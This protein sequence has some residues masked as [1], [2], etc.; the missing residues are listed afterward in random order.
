MSYLDLRLK[1]PTYLESQGIDPRKKFLCIHPEHKEQTPSS[2]VYMNKVVKCFGCGKATDIFETAHLLEGLPGRKSPSFFRDNVQVLAKRFGVL[3]PHSYSSTTIDI[4][5]MVINFITGEYAEEQAKSAQISKEELIRD[6]APKRFQPIQEDHPIVLDSPPFPHLIKYLMDRGFTKYDINEAGIVPY[7]FSKQEGAS[8]FPLW[9]NK[10]VCVG[11]IRR[12]PD[13][14]KPKYLSTPNNPVFVKTDYLYGTHFFLDKEQPL[15][16]VEGQKDVL[17]LALQSVQ[18][19]ALSGNDMSDSQFNQ[20]LSLPSSGIVM[21]LDNDERTSQDK[22]LIKGQAKMHEAIARFI[23]KGIVPGVYIWATKDANDDYSKGHFVDRGGVINGLEWYLNQINLS[24]ESEIAK[25]LGLLSEVQGNLTRLSLINQVAE[26]TGLDAKYLREDVDNLIKSKQDKTTEKV[27]H[28]YKA[29]YDSALKDPEKATDILTRAIKQADSYNTKNKD[30]YHNNELSG[31]LSS[32]SHNETI[33]SE[34]FEFY[35]FGLKHIMDY[36]SEDS[37]GWA[38]TG[39]LNLIPGVSHSGKTMFL[40][41]HMAEVLFNNINSQ[42]FLLST[43]DSTELILPRVIAALMCDKEYQIGY[44]KNQQKIP[45][46]LRHRFAKVMTFLRTLVQQ[47]RLIIKDSSSITSASTMY[48]LIK[49]YRDKYPERM[50]ILYNDNFHR[51]M[52]HREKGELQRVEYA[53]ADMKN[54]VTSEKMS[55][56]C[57]A[58]KRKTSTTWVEPYDIPANNDDILG[59]GALTYYAS[60]II[61]TVNDYVQ[62]G[63]DISKC[64]WVHTKGKELLPQS[65]LKITKNKINGRLGVFVANQYPI[66]NILEPTNTSEAYNMAFNRA[67]EFGY[68]N[69]KRES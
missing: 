63:K 13:G 11:F 15:F 21:A 19:V 46:H 60:I 26:M 25:L 58:E 68:F 48:D 3:L 32:L 10:D 38:K 23:K 67:K 49:Y 61:H 1:L 4:Y 56:W 24:D 54:F 20:I 66:S 52:D 44:M 37:N 62:R 9:T 57:S 40:V 8:L 28:I 42:V 35:G 39:S 30:I 41:Q 22:G 16:V 50:P 27:L 12:M 31:I 2:H 14:F 7:L 47:E 64:C 17:A 33:G 36:L 69:K 43:D 5:N 51:N 6:W 29:A 18:A 45:V 59:A 34:D 65:Q 53:A 55:A